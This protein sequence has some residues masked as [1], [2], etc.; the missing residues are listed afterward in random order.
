MI[1]LLLL[2]CALPAVAFV[3]AAQDAE[4]TTQPTTEPAPRTAAPPTAFDKYY[5]V[6]LAAPDERPEVT[7][8]QARQ[9]QA[10]HIGHLTKMAEEGYALVAGPFAN[11]FDETWRGMVLYRGDLSAE[12]VRELAEADPAVQAGL[13]KVELMDWYTAAG[14]LKF[15]LAEEMA[16]KAGGAD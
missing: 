9:L 7:P 13:M 1:K 15:P 8:E 6:L 12:Q 10:Q 4:P 5:F 16:A 11:R 2:A 3:A 14:A